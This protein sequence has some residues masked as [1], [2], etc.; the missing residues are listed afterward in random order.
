VVVE[1]SGVVGA[2]SVG[3]TIVVSLST[4]AGG[5]TVVSVPSGVVLFCS[6]PTRKVAARRGMIR[7]LFMVWFWVVAAP[8][9]R[10]RAVVRR[11]TARIGCQFRTEC[12]AHKN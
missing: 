7:Y 6:Q 2:G 4:D 10:P 8:Q 3:V 9:L 5:V 11:L 1:A 12:P